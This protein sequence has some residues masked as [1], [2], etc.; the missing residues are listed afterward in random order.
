MGG[1]NGII[2]EQPLRMVRLYMPYNNIISC[3]MS[4]RYLLKTTHLLRLKG[5]DFFYSES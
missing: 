3:M 2:Y 1:H 4:I 5:R